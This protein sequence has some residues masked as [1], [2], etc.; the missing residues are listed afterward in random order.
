MKRTLTALIAP[1]LLLVSLVSP[2]AHGKTIRVLHVN[3]FHGFAEPYKPFGA[4]DLLGGAAFLAAEVEWLRKEKPTLLLS[5]GDMIQ[6][7]NWANLSRGES[8]IELMNAMRF[9]AM[10]LG[11]H[12]FDFGPEVLEKRISEARFPV[13]GANVG[14]IKGIRPYI[15][16]EF[17][18]LQVAILGVVTEET[19]V[20]THPR[21]VT[22]V[23]FLRPVETVRDLVAELRPHVDI[24]VVLSHLGHHQDRLLAER[25]MGIDLIVGGHSHTRVAS[26]PLI[27]NTLVVQAWEH[28][29]ALG[30]VDLEIKDGKTVNARGRLIEIRPMPFRENPEASIIVAKHQRRVSSLLDE[31]IGYTSVDLD[32]E[33]VRRRETNLGNLITDSIRE[34]TG[35]DAVILNGGDIRTS[36]RQGPVQVKHIYAALPFNDY[37]VVAKL[38]GSEIREALEHGVSALSEGAG[39]FPQVS[40]IAFTFAPSAHQGSRVKEILINGKPLEPEKE[41]TIATNDF[42]AAGGDGYKVFSRVFG[43]E[44]GRAVYNDSSRLLRDIVVEYIRSKGE[45]A[46]VIEGRIRETL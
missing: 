41:Y 19:P 33:N 24:I 17:G 11:N 8:V 9:D 39:R 37:L 1:I 15:I 4:D 2:D 40:G 13:L 29:K 32:G 35:A 6:G 18:G 30:V 38:T 31:T 46:P 3:D 21:N 23:Q 36:I 34:S 16:R 22:A 27:N 7:S 43:R 42:L 5:A 14:G 44:G 28:G 26:P 10:V 25:V 45:V 20:A 12:E